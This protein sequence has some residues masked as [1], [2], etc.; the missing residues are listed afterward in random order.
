[1]IQFRICARSTPALICS[2]E[3]SCV[4]TFASRGASRA[5]IRFRRFWRATSSNSSSIKKP[6]FFVVSQWHRLAYPKRNIKLASDLMSLMNVRIVGCNRS[7]SICLQ[8]AGLGR[9]R[10]PCCRSPDTLQSPLP[11]E[12]VWKLCCSWSE[13]IFSSVLIFCRGIIFLAALTGYGADCTDLRIIMHFRR[14]FRGVGGCLRLHRV[15]HGGD[16]HQVHHT[17]HVVSQHMQRHLCGNV[18][19]RSHFEV[20]GSHP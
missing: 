4:I 16:T 7:M 19:Q 1:M 8:M 18:F 13:R 12:A 9:A 15:D 3:K 14:K 5:A 11:A 6:I 10:F 20:C 2:N 17:G